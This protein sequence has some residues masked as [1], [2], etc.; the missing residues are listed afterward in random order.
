LSGK[1]V[2]PLAAD[3]YHSSGIPAKNP[4]GFAITS[5]LINIKSRLIK[6]RLRM[7]CAAAKLNPDCNLSILCKFVNQG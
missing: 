6:E 5:R 7:S 3:I 2:P 4:D 1:K